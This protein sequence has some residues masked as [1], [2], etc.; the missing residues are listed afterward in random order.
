MAI[1][2]EIPLAI[3]DIKGISN[4]M[5]PEDLPLEYCSVLTN[6]YERK[7]G[8]LVRK[9]GTQEMVTAFPTGGTPVVD[10]VSGL[11]NAMILKKKDGTKTHI[12]AV[13]TTILP[14]PDQAAIA[15]AMTG[16]I[17]F[18]VG[19]GN[20]G[21]ALAAPPNPANTSLG[22]D[23]FICLQFVGY[24]INFS[25]SYAVTRTGGQN[26]LRVA[27]PANLDKR[28][29]GI[30]VLAEV[31]V[32]NNVFARAQSIWVGYI[33][34]NAS[35][36]HGINY[37]FSQAPVTQSGVNAVTGVMYGS[38]TK[39]TFTLSG[40]TGGTL[41]PGKTYYVSVLEQYVS[42][43]SAQ[44][45]TCFRAR[46]TST[47]LVSKVTLTAGQNAVRIDPVAGVLGDSPCYCIAIGEDPQLM[48]PIF[49]TNNTTNIITSLPL[50]SPCMAD[51]TPATAHVDYIWRY[52]DAS[53]RDMFFRY[54]SLSASGTLPVYA[55]RTSRI[56]QAEYVTGDEMVFRQNIDYF[57][58]LTRQTSAMSSGANYCLKQ[59]GQLGFIVN[60]SET[61]ENER[62]G[63]VGGGI[64]TRY[65]T[66]YLVTDG[67]VAAQ[68]IFDYGTTPVPKSKF[69]T[70]FQESIVVGGG[71]AGSEAYDKIYISNAY[72]PYNFSDSGS[73]TNLAFVGIDASGEPI[74]GMGIFSIST[75]D[76]GTQTQLLVG[77]R[78]K[79]F[80]INEI[81]AA[82]NFGSAFM[83]ELSNRIGLAN[84]YT[85]TNTE[86]GTVICG[87][88]DVYLIR[89][90]GEPTPIG[91]DV[92]DLFR[93][94][95]NSKFQDSSFWSAVYHDGHYK[96]AYSKPG[97]STVNQELWLNIRKMKSNKGLP[98]WYGP[99]TGREFQFSLVDTPL[100]ANDA[101]RRIIIDTVTDKNHRA[102][103]PNYLTDLGAKI[104]TIFEKEFVG[105]KGQYSNK[106]L[107]L[108][109][110]RG[111]VT[112][113][114]NMMASW[115]ADGVFLENQ[116]VPFVPA[117]NVSDILAQ[118]TKVFPFFPVNRVRGRILTLR[119]ESLTEERFGIS[120]FLVGVRPEKRRI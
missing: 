70:V 95:D 105:N 28:V 108:F 113:A 61:T 82:S 58:E 62:I 83:D 73:G 66:S 38:P 31:S 111:R 103:D 92:A 56:N 43:G 63:F 93:S 1:E 52:S 34:L 68:A 112:A 87:N 15:A 65:Q 10:Q 21:T 25:Q 77:A 2:V 64:G 85:I 75:A 80:K 7:I 96:L 106:K 41:A 117:M 55:V 49:I 22:H 110:I 74:M 59:W 40:T 104:P 67:K 12:Q 109:Q 71:A 42:N 91:Q 120:G 35:G 115:F 89:D 39:P 23:G 44:N 57:Y 47:A 99:H 90:S 119:L 97:S 5:I 60:D 46:E 19:T 51:M 94:P 11:N 18:V 50:A 118:K 14:D 24:G 69:I 17:S 88:D 27:I 81:P 48:Q 54:S 33:D 20:W 53:I 86:V 45:T 8:E 72:N 102:D 13:H 100:A 114:I 29:L 32:W 16:Q 101:E 30:N 4:Q 9:G 98:S 37:D 116:V 79:L 6:L 107:I 84:H 76:S 36:S 3:T 78:T 26:V